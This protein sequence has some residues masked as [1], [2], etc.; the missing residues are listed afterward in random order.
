[1]ATG[2]SD[3]LTLGASGPLRA[4]AAEMPG[5]KWGRLP[6]HMGVMKEGPSLTPSPLR[7]V[8]RLC[9]APPPSA[10]DVLKIVKFIIFFTD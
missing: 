8:I 5:V 10:V 1:M 6:F 3:S 7:T 2:E 4:S 9:L